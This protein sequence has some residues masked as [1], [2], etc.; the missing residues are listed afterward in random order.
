MI[1]QYVESYREF[2]LNHVWFIVIPIILLLTVMLV[3]CCVPKARAPQW[4]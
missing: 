3:A 2:Q 1:S 4:T